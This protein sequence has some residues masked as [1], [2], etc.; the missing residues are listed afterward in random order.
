MKKPLLWEINRGLSLKSEDI[1]QASKT[2][3]E[4]F[5][6]MA[7]LLSKYDGAV[8]PSAQVQPFDIDKEYPETISN[9]SLDTYH[10][11]MQVVVPASLIGL[12]AI[13][14]PAGFCENNLP[15]GIQLI[16]KQFSDNHLLQIAECWHKATSFPEKYPPSLIN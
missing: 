15:F 16:G 1:V 6:K 3:S 10:R 4:W 9:F 5:E 2:R 13:S 11:W 12:P 7:S 8:L 14:L